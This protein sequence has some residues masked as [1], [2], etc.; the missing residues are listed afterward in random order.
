[1]LIDI[2]G[3]VFHKIGRNRPY[4]EIC[5]YLLYLDTVT[6]KMHSTYFFRM[7]SHESSKHPFKQ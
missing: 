4:Y 3:A 1:M 5:R 7:N 6:M 2:Q